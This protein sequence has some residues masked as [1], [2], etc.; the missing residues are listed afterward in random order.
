MAFGMPARASVA[1]PDS[2]SRTVLFALASSRASVMPAGPE[3][4]T[5]QSYI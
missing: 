1:V 5:Q 4:I 2:K 3:P